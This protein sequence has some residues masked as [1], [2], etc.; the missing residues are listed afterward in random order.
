ML[1]IIVC[2]FLADHLGSTVALADASGTITSSTTYDSFGNAAPKQATGSAASGQATGS[3]ASGKAAGSAAS[4]AGKAAPNI[5]TS[6]RYTGREYDADTG[7]YYYRSRWY[8]PEVGRFISEDPIGFAGGDINLYGYVANNP[9]SFT[10][11]SGNYACGGQDKRRA[12]F[13]E[14][15]EAVKGILGKD[16]A[17]SRFFLG[18]GLAALKGIVDRVNSQEK[19]KKDKKKTFKSLGDNKT[20]IRMRVPSIISYGAYGSPASMADL[21]KNGP[22]PIALSPDEVSIN[23]RGAF[24]SSWAESLG[25]RRPNT[26]KSRAIQLL[27]EIGHLVATGYSHH[28]R[29]FKVGNE[30]RSYNMWK[31]T[32][33][34]APDKGKTG[35]SQRHTRLVREVCDAQIDALK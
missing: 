25:G 26:L 31:L 29:K 35:L 12:K 10:D 17:C 21:E 34:F 16:N 22:N 15:V 6:Y 14:A 1:R 18:Q 28:V 4:G 23:T 27:H 20:G 33:L 11:P 13:D 30:M 24:L 7:L 3:A 9:L 19:D 5:A 8:D 2:S 32:H